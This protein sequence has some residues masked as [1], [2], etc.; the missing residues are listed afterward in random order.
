MDFHFTAEEEAFRHEL[1][2]WLESNLPSD[3]DPEEF[4][5]GMSA[6][7]R[8]RFQMVWHRK[9]HEGGWVG[10]HWPKEY[11]GRGATLLEQLI[12][13]QE[14]ERLRAPHP[15]NFLALVM[16]GPVI[17]HWGTEEQKRRYLPKILS[18]EEIW[19]EG[20][21]EPGAGSDLASLQTRAVE[22]GDYFVI[23]GQKVW[24]SGAH[25]SHFCQLF[26]RTDPDAPKH[27]GVSCLIV[28]MKTPGVVVRPL[29]QINGDAEFNEVFFSDV[30]VPKE[31]LIGP[32]DRGWEVLVTTLMFERSGIGLDM[33][34]DETL[35]Q[36]ISL[37]R[38]LEINGQPAATDSAVRQKLAQFT[39]ECRAIR[40]NV[41]RH[42]TRRLKGHPPGAE[43]SIGKLAGSELGLRMAA[44]A[45]ELLGSYAPL[46]A[47]SPFAL[48]R[49]KWARI[50]LGARALTIAGGTSEVQRNVVGERVLGLPKG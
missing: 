28:D 25:R 30:R 3:Y 18:A 39:I 22:E 6:D 47:D 21:S 5:W 42:L 12:F 49:G 23:N 10:V 1:R 20:L 34:V 48:E 36:L 15:A 2:A 14:L 45:G 19:C 44:F 4:A 46:T 27:K 16:A 13:H 11:G 50:A 7:E 9:M 26:V 38:R 37:A 8:F 43:G 24:T 29:V 32:K 35:H 17:M 40:Y 33:P 31:N 41:L